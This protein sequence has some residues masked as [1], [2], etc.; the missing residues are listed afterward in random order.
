M[1]I[2]IVHERYR[3]GDASGENRVAD[4]EAALLRSAGHEVVVTGEDNLQLDSMSRLG[5]LVLPAQLV[6]NPRAA[7]RLAHEV[8][9]VAPDVVHVHNLFPLMSTSIL[10]V[11]R[12]VPLVA[13]LHQY[14]LLCSAQTLIR[15]GQRC[16]E[17]VGRRFP[18]AGVR[19]GCYEESPLRSVAMGLHIAVG[20]PRWRNHPV[21]LAALSQ[22]HRAAFVDAGFDP[23]QVVV[24]YNG[25]PDE[26]LAPAP[27]RDSLLYLGRLA[28]P[29]GITIAMAAWDRVAAAA[30]TAGVEFVV[31]GGGP[32][33]DQVRAWAEA[34]PAARYV[35]VLD[36]AGCWQAVSAA[37]AVVVP[38]LWAEPF[39]LAAV[40][41]MC[42]S[43]P[44][45]APADGSFPELIRD[46]VD[47]L[48]YRQGDPGALAEAMQ[49]MISAPRPDMG[50]A[51]RA[52]YERRFT[53]AANLAALEAL[54]AT[55][56]Q[57]HA[58]RRSPS[59]RA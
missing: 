57:R 15:D 21:L 1:R 2:L 26:A 40:E 24:K 34:T 48:L 16:T 5:K 38:S 18:L 43:A 51:A 50:A 8:E 55:A 10:R 31:A 19:H 22:A 59:G 4:A 42:G 27:R 49:T 46:G 37:R 11:G 36:R 56:R 29:K 30:S 39:G 17:C 52:T 3:D 44:P 45:I 47:G 41:A 12:S 13:T 7:A 25:V 6:H 20:T 32:L 58:S 53:P 54:Y 28:E 14:R 35:G 23:D 9:R 33:A